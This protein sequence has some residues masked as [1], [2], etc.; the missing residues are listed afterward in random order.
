MGSDSEKNMITFNALEPCLPPLVGLVLC[1]INVW[2]SVIKRNW[3]RNKS[4]APK[5]TTLSLTPFNAV[6]SHSPKSW[7]TPGGCSL[8]VRKSRTVSLRGG[9]RGGIKVRKGEALSGSRNKEAPAPCGSLLALCSA[10]MTT[11]G[12]SGGRN[13]ILLPDWRRTAIPC[14]Y[15]PCRRRSCSRSRRAP[16]IGTRLSACP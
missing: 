2:L 5:L 10:G 16:Y 11:Y 1:W 12:A 8:T 13:E 14:A 6:T 3:T 15:R 4:G 9:D 7:L